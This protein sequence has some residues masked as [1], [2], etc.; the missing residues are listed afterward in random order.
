MIVE[1]FFND[2]SSYAPFFNLKS[3][4]F[5]IILCVL[6]VTWSIGLVYGST[7]LIQIHAYIFNTSVGQFILLFK[8]LTCVKPIK[9]ELL[10]L[11]FT[12]AG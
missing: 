3:Y 1:F 9:F 8:Y 6:E 5:F 2:R 12:T 10:A 11:F 4:G 7:Q